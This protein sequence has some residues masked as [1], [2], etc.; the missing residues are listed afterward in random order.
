MLSS[1]PPY[2]Y[3]TLYDT[4]KYTSRAKRQRQLK[5][6]FNVK[7]YFYFTPAIA[8]KSHHVLTSCIDIIK[9]E[10]FL[11][12]VSLIQVDFYNNR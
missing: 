3:V 10:L 5:Y 1:L 7:T 12:D 8:K 4:K 11:I 6:Q 2:V 9:S